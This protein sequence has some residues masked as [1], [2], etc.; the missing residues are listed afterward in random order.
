[1]LVSSITLLN[2]IIQ[3]YSDAGEKGRK[4]I[5]TEITGN[6]ISREISRELA[7][8]F[9]TPLDR[10]DIYGINIAQENV[11]NAIKEISSRIGLY[12]LG[13]I[14]PGAKELILK[15]KSMIEQTAIMME[16]LSNRKEVKEHARIIQD[17]KKESDV[18]FLVSLGEIFEGEN[19]PGFSM[20]DTLKWSHLY[21]KID[22]AV[23]NTEFLANLIEGISL[24]NA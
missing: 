9:I 6:E 23:S 2:E 10:E 13:C 12:N 21:D 7:L 22:V 5:L 8:T 15:L 17:I 14:K 4:I 24:K 16:L 18:F 1:M 11:L 3:D 20:M 19:E